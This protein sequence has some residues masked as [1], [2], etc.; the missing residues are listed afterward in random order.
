MQATPM[1]ST[2]A[3]TG[4]PLALRV[5]RAVDA[6]LETADG[7]LEAL[8]A[9]GSLAEPARI[10][11]I[12]A[13]AE[14][15]QASLTAEADAMTVAQFESGEA[16]TVAE[17]GYQRMVALEE[18]V[19]AGPIKSRADALAK[20]K[21]AKLWFD[22]GGKADGEDERAWAEAVAWLGGAR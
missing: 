22:R 19:L 8:N 18:A 9:E 21:V 13:E 20:L 5:T 12:W 3:P 16:E 7:L 4:V 2:P 11:T 17:D 15:L 1:I 14:A 6:L 10:A